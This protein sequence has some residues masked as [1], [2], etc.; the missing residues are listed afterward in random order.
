[1]VWEGCLCLSLV[2]FI[3]TVS[4]MIFVR[5]SRRRVQSFRIFIGGV[6][7]S[8]VILFMPI[9]LE[10]FQ[11]EGLHGLKALLVSVH[12]TFRLFVVDGEFTFVIDN[13]KSL[14]G[15]LDFAYS[16]LLA[17]FHVLAP[18]LTFGFVL[19]FFKNL[20]TYVTYL[21]HYFSNVYIFSE[22]NA[23]SLELAKSL[24]KNDKRRFIIFT[25][26]FDKNDEVSFELIEEA[27]TVGNVAFKKD[28]TTINFSVHSKRRKLVFF[29]IGEDEAEN[30]KQALTLI[31]RHQKRDNTEIYIFAENL[32]SE[33]V[34]GATEYGRVKVRRVNETRF[35]IN[36]FL[37]DEGIEIFRNA[38]Q[39]ESG[40]KQIKAI[41]VGLGP[42]G[43]EMTRALPWFC[44]MDGYQ[45]RIWA[46]D[47][48]EK[49][50]ERFR[51]L[52]P[53]LMDDKHNGDFTTEGE[54]H[55]E[56]NIHAGV[57][58]WSEAFLKELEQ[59]EGIT[60]IFVA[61]G[62]DEKNI[63][64]AAEIRSRFEKT[65][66]HPQIVAIAYDVEKQALG[67]IKNHSGQEYDIHFIGDIQSSY[68]EEVIL[69]SDVEEVALARH[70]KWG[71][72]DDFWRYEYNYRS[73]IASAIHRKMKIECGIPGANQKPEE[74][75]EQAKQ[76]LRVL[77][78]QRWNAYMRSEGF[79]FAEKRNNLAKTHHCL[80]PFEDLTLEEKVKDDD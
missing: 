65:E 80:I 50:K 10:I 41:V 70:L 36:R 72:E 68:S 22:L 26:V 49:S 55:Y 23:K 71:K 4:I 16:L 58:V 54:A 59:I 44:Q 63:R 57:D 53:E 5:N 14:N 11:G 34:L 32:E 77:E 61:L 42:H 73:S 38:K 15:W 3:L 60:Y 45:I 52:C 17:V 31:K 35:L 29:H 47:E 40:E 7:L 8:S 67:R 56:I 78:H 20:S 75:E 76:N 79:T 46:F 27:Q 39:S 2:V 51:R 62:E 66:Q 69:E 1:M 48:D 9:Y 6:F 37:Y 12:H 74:R 33:M 19:S 43:T 25:E 18:I 64:M 21:L 30:V 28:V 13:T 24:K